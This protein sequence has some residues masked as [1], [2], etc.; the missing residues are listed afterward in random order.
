MSNPQTF[1]CLTPT[2]QNLVAPTHPH[3]VERTNGRSQTS[4]VR[5]RLKRTVQIPTCV[6]E[7]IDGDPKPS[8]IL[9][10]SRDFGGNY[11]IQDNLYLQSGSPLCYT[12]TQFFTTPFFKFSIRSDVTIGNFISPSKRYLPHPSDVVFVSVASAL[13]PNKPANGNLL[14]AHASLAG[15]PAYYDANG[16]FT[17]VAGSPCVGTF[18]S[19]RDADGF[20]R[21]YVDVP[22]YGRKAGL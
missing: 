2:S 5:N 22:A 17:T 9:C 16:C 3:V 4:M 21:V 19:E 10:S 13:N 11:A 8:T 20:A 6:L 14:Y 18:Q 15:K 1:L 7:T 12:D